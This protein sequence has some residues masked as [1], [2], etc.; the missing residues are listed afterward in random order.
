MDTKVA[1]FLFFYRLFTKCNLFKY[2]KHIVKPLIWQKYLWI[3][4]ANLNKNIY[5]G[6]KFNKHTPII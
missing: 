5:W 1:H 3:Q 6:V 2:H 4:I